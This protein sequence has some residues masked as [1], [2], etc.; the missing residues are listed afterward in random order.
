MKPYTPACYACGKM[1]RHEYISLQ[2]HYIGTLEWMDNE[3]VEQ[4]L[5]VIPTVILVLLHLGSHQTQRTFVS[6]WLSLD[7]QAGNLVLA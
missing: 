3:E 5:Q 7:L 2:Y 6:C 1:L 4:S